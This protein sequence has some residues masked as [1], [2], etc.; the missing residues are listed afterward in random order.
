MSPGE[1]R[2]PGLPALRFFPYQVATAR[3]GRK[4]KKFSLESLL[5]NTNALSKLTG[6]SALKKKRGTA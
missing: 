5:R 3:R 6:A 1:K 4:M 2:V